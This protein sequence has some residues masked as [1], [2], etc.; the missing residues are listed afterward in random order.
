VL[1]PYLS[2]YL[3]LLA[4]PLRFGDLI[5][6]GTLFRKTVIVVLILRRFGVR[7]SSVS[8]VG[9]HVSLCSSIGNLW[10]V[11]RIRRSGFAGMCF[12]LASCIM[13]VLFLHFVQNVVAVRVH[14]HG[15]K[16]DALGVVG[17]I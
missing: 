10:L 13:I 4:H 16:L 8:I 6:G 9:P 2:L 3:G 1:D 5:F 7:P 15:D 11:H 14:R 12:A 17:H